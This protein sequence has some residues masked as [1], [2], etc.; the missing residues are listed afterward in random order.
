MKTSCV[1]ANI[2]KNQKK[3]QSCQGFTMKHW[4]DWQILVFLSTLAIF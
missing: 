3:C 1:I 4:Q 2:D